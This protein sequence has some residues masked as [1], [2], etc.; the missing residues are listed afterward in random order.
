[1][2]VA[3]L[4]RYG[5]VYEGGN[6]VGRE[7]RKSIFNAYKQREV[8]KSAVWGNINVTDKSHRLQRYR[9]RTFKPFK[10]LSC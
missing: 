4:D 10:R 7:G 1:M 9:G 5:P 2:S 3:L 6:A 8:L